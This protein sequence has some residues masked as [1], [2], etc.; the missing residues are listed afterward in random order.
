MECEKAINLYLGIKTR[1]WV[2]PFDRKRDIKLKEVFHQTNHE[3]RYLVLVGDR[4]NN[5]YNRDEKIIYRIIPEFISGKEMI[6]K[7]KRL[8][9]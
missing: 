6:K 8:D 1:F 4:I 9:I 2:L 5:N 7:L 3:N